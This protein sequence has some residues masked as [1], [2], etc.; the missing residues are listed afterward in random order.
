MPPFVAKTSGV[1]DPFSIWSTRSLYFLFFS[2]SFRLKHLLSSRPLYLWALR[3]KTRTSKNTRWLGI[4]NPVALT[5]NRASLVMFACFLSTSPPSSNKLGSV[6][7]S[8]QT[9]ANSWLVMSRTSCLY[10]SLFLCSYIFF[11]SMIWSGVRNGTGLP[12]KIYTAVFKRSH[13]T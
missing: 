2:S 8:L 9:S 13:E 10:P 1:N 11:V 7:T 12:S 4:Q 6:R 5:S 3:S